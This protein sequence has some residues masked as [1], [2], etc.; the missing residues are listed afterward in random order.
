MLHQQKRKKEDLGFRDHGA[1]IA[2]IFHLPLEEDFF[3]RSFRLG[4]SQW[5]QA[6]SSSII[7]MAKCVSATVRPA[8]LSAL[9]AAVGARDVHDEFQA[10]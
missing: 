3:A 2:F 1:H 8:M 9:G 4:H 10:N 5:E 7:I 6:K